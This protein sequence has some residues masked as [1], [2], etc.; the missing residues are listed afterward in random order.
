MMISQYLCVRVP[1]ARQQDRGTLDISEQKGERLRGQ[2]PKT[3]I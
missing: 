3:S 2:Q 1:K